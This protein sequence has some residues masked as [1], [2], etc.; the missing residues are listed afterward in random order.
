MIKQITRDQAADAIF[1]LFKVLPWEKREDG[2][3]FFTRDSDH[4]CFWFDK[5]QYLRGDIIDKLRAYFCDKNIVDG[6]CRIDAMTLLWTCV[7]IEPRDAKN[8]PKD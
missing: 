5:R 3:S 7:H 4:T 6:Q 8:H 2:K 1:G